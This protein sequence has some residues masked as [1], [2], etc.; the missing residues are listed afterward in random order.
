[1]RSKL[2]PIDPIK[3]DQRKAV[4]ARRVG[5]GA[6]CLCGEARPEALIAGTKPITCAACKR[7]SKGQTTMDSHHIAGKA[8][9]PLTVPVPVNDHRAELSGAQHDWSKQMRENPD[10]SPF[11]AAAACVRGFIDTARY[12]V[13]KLLVWVAEMLEMLDAYLA[14]RLGPQWWVGKEL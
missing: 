7:R 3:A 5:E 10:A 14:K 12:L 9:S 11:I 4:A 13:E 8:N 6:K 2:P 1:M